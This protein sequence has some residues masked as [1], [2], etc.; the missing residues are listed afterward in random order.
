MKPTAAQSNSNQHVGVLTRRYAAPLVAVAAT[1]IAILAA[2]MS[3]AAT[4]CTSSGNGTVCQ[5][6]G[7]AQVTTHVPPVKF[8]PYGDLA[9]PPVNDNG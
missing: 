2:P 6:P 8:H 4:T 3:H 9:G 5:S 7:N 1:A